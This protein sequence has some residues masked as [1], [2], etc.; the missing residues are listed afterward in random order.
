MLSKERIRR[1]SGQDDERESPSTP[2]RF[3]VTPRRAALIAAVLATLALI[4]VVGSFL[5][6]GWPLL[7]PSLSGPLAALGIA[8]A[9]ALAT[10][11]VLYLGG[12]L[13]RWMA[14]RR[15]IPVFAA[16]GGCAG[17]LTVIQVPALQA[18]IL[19]LLVVGL[20]A[21]LAASIV[22]A[23][24]PGH[25]RRR[26]LGFAVLA[27]SLA[28]ADAA[29]ILWWLDHGDARH[30]AQLEVAQ[31]TA[32]ADSA[33]STAPPAAPKVPVPDASAVGPYEVQMLSYGAGGPQAVYDEAAS[34]SSRTEDLTPFLAAG[35]AAAHRRRVFG[36]GLDEV[37]LNARAWRP[38]AVSQD[39]PTVL[40]IHGNH[41]MAT[42]SEPGLDYLGRHLAS[43]GFLAVAPDMNVLNSAYLSE[44][45]EEIDARAWLTLSHL[46]L[47]AQWAQQD[48]THPIAGGADLRRTLLVG[49]SRGGEA[50]AVAAAL[51]S[52]QRHPDNALLSLDFNE[53]QVLAVAA[54]A[55]TANRYRPAGRELSVDGISYLAIQGAHD[56]DVLLFFGS[57]QL[58]RIQL[59]KERYGFKASIVLH[60]G[61]HAGFNQGWGWHDIE[62]PMRGILNRA[63]LLA[64][65]DQRRA[66]KGFLG[67]FAQVT[68]RDDRRFLPAFQ[69]PTQLA[70]W[71]PPGALVGRFRDSSFRRI[72][73]FEEDLDPTTGSVTGILLQGV[74]LEGWRERELPSRGRSGLDTQVAHLTWPARAPQDPEARFSITG[75]LS[76]SSL[77]SPSS[78]GSSSGDAQGDESGDLLPAATAVLSL[79]LVAI[80]GGLSSA[81]KL[82]LVRADGHRAEVDLQALQPLSPPLH[83]RR[84][85]LPA[86]GALFG[87]SWEP[88]PQ[89]YRI[90]LRDLDWST[91]E[92]PLQRSGTASDIASDI[93]PPHLNIVL[94]EIHLL[95][96][97]QGGSLYVDNVGL[98]SLIPST[99]DPT[100]SGV[101]P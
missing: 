42:P 9:G 93:A 43:H 41:L 91:P 45:S 69:N 74:G 66:A 12:R 89:T 16:A 83:A 49:H 51:S 65:Q 56:A 76:S 94:S 19:S 2:A 33:A 39:L 92:A 7:P 55:P 62:G 64:A 98:A 57:R 35:R 22:I 24:L 100:S 72:A 10:A 31:K 40:L 48:S 58:E 28:A 73:D 21:A 17:L 101:F 15:L 11:L 86:E 26:R 60:R 59:P 71:R 23:L 20:Q 81:P 54:L 32:V 75:L 63:P 90:P 88:S 30:L 99:Q 3:A 80:P 1:R 18:L 38:V 70:P 96:P 4:F 13:G 85:K 29:L 8:L 79:D 87:R 44:L 50:A 47:L 6:P 82:E 67:A 36:H 27:L 5:T 46:R 97:A 52:L 95:L 78:A 14:K 84:S 37:P 53:F 68:L 25:A 77:S 34:I 61:H